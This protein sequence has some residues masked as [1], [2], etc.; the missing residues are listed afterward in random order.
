[1]VGDTDVPEGVAGDDAK[2]RRPPSSAWLTADSVAG[3]DRRERLVAFAT[4]QAEATAQ[5]RHEAQV[6]AWELRRLQGRRSVR[7]A[8]A[9]AGLRSKG[10]G[11]GLHMLWRARSPRPNE[12][13][14][15]R[16]SPVPRP[17][18]PR[19]APSLLDPPRHEH[20]QLRVLHLGATARYAA[21]AP[22][23]SL[24]AATWREELARGGDLLLI[25]APS[26]GELPTRLEEVVD[27]ARTQQIPVV[28]VS[29]G[30]GSAPGGV[31]DH[32]DLHVREEVGVTDRSGGLR[33]PPTVDPEVFNPVGWRSIGPD[34][35]VAVLTAER[36]TSAALQALE[37]FDP[38]VGLVVT[39][40]VDVEA[41][42]DE[43]TVLRTLDDAERLRRSLGRTSVLL[44]HPGFHGGPV[45]ASRIRA[46][47]AATGVCVVA[48]ERAVPGEDE[49]L[50]VPAT[51]ASAI[52]V[53]HRLLTDRDERE[54]RSIAGRRAALTERT[55]G[56]TFLKILESLA[57]PARPEP[58]VSVVVA[59]NR[60]AQ[61][62]HV[63]R[64]FEAQS[65][66]EKE[67]ILVLHG[68]G[69][70]DQLPEGPQPPT[71]VVR[72]P[73]TVSLGDCLNA[74]IRASRGDLVAKMDDD[75]HYGPD[76]LRDLVLAWR[77]SGADLVGK[78]VEYVHIEQEDLTVRRPPRFPERY[79]SHVSG[80]SLLMTAELARRVGFR[81]V[82]RRVDTTL[83][84]RVQ[85]LGG[86]IYRTHSRDLVLARHTDPHTWDVD[87]DELV[88]DAEAAHP[89]LDRVWAS[90]SP[91][92]AVGV[93]VG[94]SQERGE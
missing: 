54:R 15:E 11:A 7:V 21:C 64:S 83:C 24:D 45:S 85:E 13:H 57:L 53:V 71:A 81:S 12:P 1:V 86:R 39:R 62:V 19:Q 58:L 70:P 37:G 52:D 42:P 34:P 6:T 5:A 75:D 44:D 78:R 50:V 87:H 88:T 80:P 79:T 4:E 89:G 27:A 47:A 38:P 63:H 93:S 67:L 74:G 76:H 55:H 66:P 17:A 14:P 82:R 91:S 49:P 28:L 48:L 10:L 94:G 20:P 40:D 32:C 92:V 16:P 73:A 29:D 36:P 35:V 65:Y 60:P 72:L 61:L 25:E 59:T 23:R 9:L 90:S 51:A 56:A 26:D 68:D 8:L 3:W 2:P 18:A 77:Y 31:A 41:L 69:F 33:V 84:E 46:A 30:D 43:L 22:H